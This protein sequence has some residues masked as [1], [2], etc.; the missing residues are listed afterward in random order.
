MLKAFTSDV[1]ASTSTLRHPDDGA[2]SY[3]EKLS[4]LAELKKR[5]TALDVA[6]REVSDLYAMINECGIAVPEIEAAE[7]AT[8]DNDYHSLKDAVAEVDGMKDDTVQVCRAQF[9]WS[10]S[11]VLSA[12]TS[13]HCFRDVAD[14]QAYNID[15]AASFEELKR[16]VTELRNAAQHEMILDESC[17]HETVCPH[18]LNAGLYIDLLVSSSADSRQRIANRVAPTQ[19]RLRLSGRGKLLF[20]RLGP[21]APCIVLLLILARH[22]LLMYQSEMV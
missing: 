14:I 10:S 4:F 21:L 12:R 2:A 1:H 3:A 9:A 15:L 13:C 22:R 17:E 6:C 11:A 19:L 20:S 18:C 5:D 7:L 8:M 16:Q